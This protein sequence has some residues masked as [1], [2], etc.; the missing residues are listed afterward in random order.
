MPAEHVEH[1]GSGRDAVGDVER[2]LPRVSPSGNTVSWWPS[3]QHLWIAAARPV[4]VRTGWARRPARRSRRGAARSSPRSGRGGLVAAHRGRA[5][6]TRSRPASAGRRAWRRGRTRRQRS[7]RS[8]A[9]ATSSRRAHAMLGHGQTSR[10]RNRHRRGSSPCRA[11]AATTPRHR[12]TRQPPR[13]RQRPSRPTPSPTSP[14]PRS[15]RPTR[16][17]LR[18]PSAVW[19]RST[20]RSTPWYVQAS[21]RSRSSMRRRAPSSCSSPTTTSTPAS[22]LA[23]RMP[24]ARWSSAISMPTSTT[25]SATT[26]CSPCRSTSSRATSIPTRRSTPSSGW[27]S[28]T[29]IT[30][31]GYIKTRDGTTLSANVVLPGPIEDGPYPTVVEYSGYTPSDPERVPASRTLFTPLGYAY[32]GV[33]MRGTGC[34]GGSFRYFE[35]AQSDRRL[36]RHRGRR[37]AAVG[38]R[39]PGRHGRRLLP[40]HQPALRRADPAAEPRGD[41]A[42]LG[43]R[44]QLQLDALSGRHPQHRLRRR[45]DAGPRR[46]RQAG[47]RSRRQIIDEG[48]Q[49]WAKDRIAAGDDEC[50]ANQALRLQ[51]PDLVAEILDSP[52]YDSR[53]SATSISPRLF[54]DKINVPTFVAGAWQ[55]EQTGGRFPTMLDRFTGTDHLYVTLVNGLHT[56]SIGPANFPRWVEFL[57][58][59]VA[60]RTPTLGAA[61]FVAPI[62]AGGLFG[63]DDLATSRRPVRRGVVRRGARRLRGRAADRACCSRR[64]LPTA[65]RARPRSPASS[66]SST[67]G[68][69]RPSNRPTWFLGADGALPDTADA[70]STG[71]AST[72]RCPTGSRRPSTR[73]TRATSGGPTSSGNGSEPAPGTVASS[74]SAPLDRHHHD[75]RIGIG[76]SVGQLEPRR[77]R[78]RGH[79]LRGPPRRPGDVRAVGLAARQPSHS[80]T[81]KRRPSSAGAHPSRG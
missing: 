19:F 36:R 38:V 57:D 51:N 15:R 33:N 9:Q 45:V 67:R 61:R 74:V 39:E 17:P 76:R 70:D 59:Y 24:T 12:M 22:P 58:L 35:Y 20:N 43:D 2:P 11:R 63:T 26:R 13:H 56:E 31:F 8:P 10:G 72:S 40:R 32:V 16:R 7:T 68:R 77:H 34:S 78:S 46:Q 81:T 23:Q 18:I 50:A 53:R 54:V 69:S 64:V 5:T 44:R 37:R 66:T 1:A 65:P 4:H 60:K 27:R 73:A 14:T 52:F 71:R 42:V 29:E 55:D 75:G 48:G 79:A 28:R 62:L 25:A 3:D 80:S 41:H 49:G 47:R 30:G 21:S 6:A